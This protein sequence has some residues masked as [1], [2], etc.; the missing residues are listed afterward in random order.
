[1]NTRRIAPLFCLAVAMATITGCQMFNPASRLYGTWKLDADATIDR[2]AGGNELAKSLLKA[3]LAL[4]V[5]T[6]FRD[7][8]TGETRG[9]SIALFGE[10]SESFTWKLLSAE[11]DTLRVEI[12]SDLGKREEAL[13]M[14][15]ADTFEV[16]FTLTGKT[17]T[18][19]FR[20]VIE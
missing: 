4:D 17:F 5:A 8:G 11:N 6:E 18:S 1:M 12:I 7:D 16:D 19:I 10:G 2:A 15:D 20:R 9:N 13:R 14:I 3:T